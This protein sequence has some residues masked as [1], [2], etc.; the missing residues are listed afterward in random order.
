VNFLYGSMGS[1]CKQCGIRFAGTALGRKELDDHLDM[2]FQQNRRATQNM[3]RGHSRGWFT[4]L[5]VSATLGDPAYANSV[6]DWIDSGNG[7]GKERGPRVRSK[8]IAAEAARAEADLKAQ[9][10]VIPPGEESQ[11][12]A[13]PICKETIKSEFLEDEEEWVWRNAVRKDD[14]VRCLD[15]NIRCQVVERGVDIPCDMP[16]GSVKKCRVAAWVDD[17]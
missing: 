15:F 11:A 17:A 9:F 8:G 2:H 16:R 10:I 3:G 4:S 12:T 7:K 14:K 6:Q 13:C 5:D 1:R